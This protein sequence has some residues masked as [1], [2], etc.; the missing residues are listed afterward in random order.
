MKTSAMKEYSSN[1]NGVLFELDR[2]H[3]AAHVE[4]LQKV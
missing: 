1:I 2:K 3:K 4:A